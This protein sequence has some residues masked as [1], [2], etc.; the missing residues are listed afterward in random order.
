M[1]CASRPE[2]QSTCRRCGRP[3]ARRAGAHRWWHVTGGDAGL[4]CPDG[5]GTAT[6]NDTG[7]PLRVLLLALL[8][9]GVSEIVLHDDGFEI[10]GP[11]DLSLVFV[12]GRF[13]PEQLAAALGVD[14]SNV[15]DLR[16]ASAS[17]DVARPLPHN[18]TTI[19]RASTWRHPATS[20]EL[21]DRFMLRALGVEVGV[22]RSGDCVLV[23]V[24]G[25][26]I[27]PDHEPLAVRVNNGPAAA[28]G[29]SRRTR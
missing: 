12:G 18:V 8:A 2:E 19:G 17:D 14:E 6:P 15:T 3:I 27:H 29:W 1:N 24:D 7:S 4:G 5:A 22:Q 13:T 26:G 11:E 9:A 20:G 16:T 21:S 10:T 28:Y 23:T 25:H